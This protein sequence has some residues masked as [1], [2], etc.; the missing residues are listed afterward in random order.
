MRSV[1]QFTKLAMISGLAVFASM[2]SVHA[3]VIYQDNYTTRIVHGN[4]LGQTPNEVTTGGTY[5]VTNASAPSGDALTYIEIGEPHAPGNYPY[6]VLQMKAPGGANALDLGS[7]TSFF[8]PYNKNMVG[9]TDILK[10][11]MTVRKPAP[12]NDY[13]L[14]D[15]NNL[16]FG[17]TGADPAIVDTNVLDAFVRLESAQNVSGVGI[18]G[19]VRPFVPGVGSNNGNTS[20]TASSLKM[21][22]LNSNSEVFATISM[23]Y[24]PTK[25]AT[26]PWSLTWDGLKVDFPKHAATQYAAIQQITGVGFGN[27]GASN[28]T[29]RTAWLRDFKFEVIPQPDP[30]IPGDLDGDGFVGQT[31]L[32]LILGSW[33]QAV[34]PGDPLADADNSGSIGQGDLN[35]VLGSW[36]QGDP[37]VAAVPEPATVLLMGLAGIG[38]IA[39]RVRSRRAA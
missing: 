6:Q 11:T 31:D 35:L 30:G 10:L 25:V 38:L 28:S 26:Q 2:S 18:T 15:Y 29:D 39:M 37:P 1:Y 19:V 8:L 13:K 7:K 27:F 23:E 4:I 34:P 5:Q 32:N 36:G 20:I 16:I 3:Q 22:D 33:G 9:S 24:D 14:W 12:G 17:F 21:I